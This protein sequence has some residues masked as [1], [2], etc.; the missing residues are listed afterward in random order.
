MNKILMRTI[1]STTFFFL[2]WMQILP[3]QNGIVKSY[4]ADGKVQTEASYVNDVLDGAVITYFPNGKI[5]TEKNFSQGVLD[6]YVR[7]YYATGLMKEEYFVKK[8]IKD[9]SHR[10]FF[11]NGQLQQL[12]EYSDG[13]LINRHVFNSDT[14]YKITNELPV[15]KKELTP[16]LPK[17]ETVEK[18]EETIIPET[19]PEI[20]CDVQV[21]PVPIGGMKGIQKILVYPEHALRYGIQ[22]TV[23]IIATINNSGDVI[24]T[25]VLK[26]LGYGC[27]EAAQEA[28]RKTKF[29][30][31]INDNKA[32]ECNATIPIQ[33]RILNKK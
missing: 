6:G 15:V 14:D 10:K 22:G 19:E 18:K 11:E 13:K 17:K 26:G 7:E 21:C 25:Q 1:Y 28:L 2:L 8:G 4:Y 23:T 30:P 31:G 3:A 5:E 32:S 20:L 27:D 24:R 29:V 33:F 9:G 16:V 12:S